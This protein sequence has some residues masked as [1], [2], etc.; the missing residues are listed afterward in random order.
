M[1]TSENAKICPKCLSDRH[2]REKKLLIGKA[3]PKLLFSEEMA[4]YRRRDQLA[5]DECK[6]DVLK[7]TPLEQ[8]ID[9]YYCDKCGIGFVPDSFAISH[10]A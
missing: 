9:G 10:K 2:V 1:Q 3:S 7:E 6:S 8:F 5:V 4:G